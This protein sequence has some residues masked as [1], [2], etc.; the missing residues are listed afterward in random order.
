MQDALMSFPKP[1]LLFA[2]LPP[3][4]A[5]AWAM[6]WADSH[7]KTSEA[8]CRIAGLDISSPVLCF[9]FAWTIEKADAMLAFWNGRVHFLT[10]GFGLDFLF[11]LLY[12]AISFLFL[13]LVA[14]HS[15]AHWL[16]CVA[17]FWA[18]FV[19][20]SGFFDAVENV[21]L[22]RY[23]FSHRADS[24]LKVAGICAGIK[25]ALLAVSGFIILIGV[26]AMAFEWTKNR[27]RD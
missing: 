18:P 1:R 15:P 24:L 8:A 5:V 10:F 26:V 25:F 20:V 11:L 22:L 6:R 14:Q 27:S 17:A 16:K 2:L 12:P 4:L 3:T 19:L 7:L 9:E 21:C 13:R 23:I